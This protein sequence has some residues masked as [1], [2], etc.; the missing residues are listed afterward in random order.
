MDA[1]NG[2]GC[3]HESQGKKDGVGS[4]NENKKPL[5]L[6]ATVEAV[7]P[8]GLQL[9]LDGEEKAGEKLYKCA[10][11]VLFK[12]G[13]R[14]K[15]TED[16]GT[17][18]VDFVLGLPMERLLVPAGGLD[19]Q[20]LTKD[21]SEDYVL[22][23]AYGSG[24][25]NTNYIPE[26][27]SNGQLLAKDG[28]N[29][30]SLK[31]VDAPKNYI[32]AGG[33]TGQ[34]LMKSSYSDYALKWGDVTVEATTNKLVSSI[35]SVELATTTLKPSHTTISLGSS[36]YPFGSLYAQG[37]VIFGK[38]YS[39]TKLGFFGST[40]ATKQTVASSATVSTLITALKAYGLIG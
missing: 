26:G 40:G 34:V 9:I 14:V 23:W 31:W 3:K 33:T 24:S 19:G 18:I 22:K 5:F 27:G 38:A 20:V 12:P 35:Y 21:G 2:A 13:D 8:E 17:Y 29:D 7:Q 1:E 36:S 28:N 15:L 32:P 39:S 11:N 4:V 25:T 30:F 10:N 6:L 16:S 37:D